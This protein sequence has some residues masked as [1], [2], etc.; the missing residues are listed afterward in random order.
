M[1]A[2]QRAVRVVAAGQARGG[3]RPD[4]VRTLARSR[5]LLRLVSRGVVELVVLLALLHLLL[6][7]V[8]PEGPLPRAGPAVELGVTQARRVGVEHAPLA[9]ARL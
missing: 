9:A 7:D 1:P 4:L 8:V 2:R 6:G 3:P 5:T